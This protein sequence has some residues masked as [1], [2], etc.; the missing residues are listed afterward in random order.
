VETPFGMPLTALAA[1]RDARWVRRLYVSRHVASCLFTL[2]AGAA[3]LILVVLL[4]R[5]LLSHEMPATRAATVMVLAG[6][7]ALLA[8]LY[9]RASCSYCSSGPT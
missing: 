3:G 4:T 1:R 6:C 9:Q 7:A 8:V 2:A 5:L